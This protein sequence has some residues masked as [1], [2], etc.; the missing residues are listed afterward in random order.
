MADNDKT[1]LTLAPYLTLSRDL[2]ALLTPVQL[3]ETFRAELYR[4]LMDRACQQTP[5]P[6]FLPVPSHNAPQGIPTRFVR[7]VVSVPSEDRRWVWGAA[8]VGSA[9]SLAGIVTYVWHRRSR[10]A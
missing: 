2:A 7:W 3:R 1:E 8:A 9:V 5:E 10:A 6:L 4:S